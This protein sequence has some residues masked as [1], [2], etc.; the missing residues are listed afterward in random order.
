MIVIDGITIVNLII[1][2][3]I[4][5]VHEFISDIDDIETIPSTITIN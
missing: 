5:V 4:S 3:G 1:S 2:V